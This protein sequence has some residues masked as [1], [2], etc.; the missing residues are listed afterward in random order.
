MRTA[1][2]LL[3]FVCCGI[4]CAASKLTTP[5]FE[6]TIETRCAEGVVECATVRYTGVNRKTGKSIT[7][8]GRDLHTR[9]ADGVTPCRFLGYQFR[10][11][12]LVYQVWE[13]GVLEVL[14]GNRVLVRETG[15]WDW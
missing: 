1:L 9:C 4:A 11:G 14:D 15:T 10:N 6:V 2:A 7:L 5:S 12:R 8:N 3:L 13:H